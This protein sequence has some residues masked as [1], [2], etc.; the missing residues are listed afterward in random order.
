MVKQGLKIPLSGVPQP[1]LCAS[2]EAR[3]ALPLALPW[4]AGTEQEGMWGLQKKREVT[5]ARDRG[6]WSFVMEEGSWEG[7]R[8]LY[9][10]NLRKTEKA[11]GK[12][13]TPTASHRTMPSA[14]HSPSPLCRLPNPLTLLQTFYS[15]QNTLKPSW[16]GSHQPPGCYHPLTATPKFLQTTVLCCC[17]QHHKTESQ[18][19]T[20]VILSQFL[21]LLWNLELAM[22]T[23]LLSF[24]AHFPF[25]FT[26]LLIYLNIRLH[27]SIHIRI[28]MY[29][30]VCA[31]L[32]I[33]SLGLSGHTVGACMLLYGVVFKSVPLPHILYANISHGV[34]VVNWG[35]IHI[36]SH[37]HSGFLYIYWAKV[38][39]DIIGTDAVRGSGLAPEVHPLMS[40]TSFSIALWGTKPGK[41]RR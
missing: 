22:H 35:R 6:W 17:H 29:M 16:L 4:V 24:H 23:C 3:V 13:V 30:C 34:S 36:D 2:P 11:A 37:A 32:P 10:I 27:T 1:L 19:I 7:G 31:Q 41:T 18:R 21:T 26:M 5:P 25:L 38:G 12:A 9:P 20:G 15:A 33:H 40:S 8:C 14:S 28:H 39:T